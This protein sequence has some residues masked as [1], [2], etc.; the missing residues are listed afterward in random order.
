MLGTPYDLRLGKFNPV[1]GNYSQI[2][3]EAL[4]VLFG[5]KRFIQFLLGSQFCIRNDHLPLRKMLGGKS[6]IPMNCSPLLQRVGITK[7]AI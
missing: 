1:E 2:E 6:G 5:W 7:V 4:S 3:R